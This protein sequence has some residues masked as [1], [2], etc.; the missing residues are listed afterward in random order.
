M[1]DDVVNN[2]VVPINDNHLAYVEM[3]QSYIDEYSKVLEL[4]VELSKKKYMVEKLKRNREVHVDYLK[5]AKAHADTLHAIVEQARALK[6]L[7]NALDYACKFTTRIQELLVYVNDTCL[8]SCYESGKLV[9][10]TPINKS[11]QIKN[12]KPRMKD[13]TKASR[14]QPLGNTKKNMISPTASSNQK[15]KVEDHLGSMIRLL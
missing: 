15:N 8:S 12:A 14:S 6:P 1:H 5:Q 11:R 10:V 4:D 7:D 13:S 3:E 9:A 2:C